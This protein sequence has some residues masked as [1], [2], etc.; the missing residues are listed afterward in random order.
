MS[1]LDNVINGSIYKAKG[2]V[3]EVKNSVSGISRTDNGSPIGLVGRFEKKQPPGFTPNE[4]YNSNGVDLLKLDSSKSS[5]NISSSW[6]G[7]LLDKHPDFSGIGASEKYV[8]LGTSDRFDQSKDFPNYK[9]N[10]PDPYRYVSTRDSYLM[11][12]DLSTDYFKHGLHIIDKKTPLRSDGTDRETWDGHENGTPLRLSQILNGTDKGTPYENN[13]PVIFGF[14]LVFD[15]VSSPL[16]NGSV[17]DFISQFSKISEVAARGNMIYDFK[18]QFSKLFK[19][20]GSIVMGSISPSHK[21]LSIPTSNYATADN[22][23]SNVYQQGKKAYMSY[24]LKSISGLENL[25]ESNTPDKKKYITDYRK[26][27]LKLKFTEDVSLNLG[28]LSHL[29][30]LLYWSKPLGKNIIPEN[31]LRFNC[32]IIVSEVRNLNRVRKAIDTGNLEVVKDNLSRHIYSLKECQLWFDQSPH[33]NEV[34]MSQAAKDFDSFTVTMDYKYVT[35]KFERW[36]PDSKGFGQYA[37]YNN[38]AIWKIGN[39]GRTESKTIASSI[40]SIYTLGTNTL[41]QNGVGS[42][43]VMQT[44]GNVI[45][46]IVQNQN[47]STI[48]KSNESDN[49]SNGTDSRKQPTKTTFE[50][51]KDASK[52][53]STKLAKNLEKAFKIEAQTQINKRFQLLNNTLDKIRNEAGLGRM[54]E[55]TNVYRGTLIGSAIKNSLREFAG[56]SLSSILGD[57]V[58]KLFKGGN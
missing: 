51:F 52:K 29:Y 16:L 5:I 38:G 40:P 13:D 45:D 17:E 48:N 11:F 43:I 50:K 31:L 56:D 24:Y 37:G 10:I 22:S 2:T 35:S 44:Y 58:G 47:D 49:S 39:P 46:P 25:I 32:D 7:V 27:V 1:F 21:T 33:D 42:P 55:P 34:D 54:T 57:S 20:K 6:Y 41:K 15:A 26:D 53:S 19:T 28:T 12:N 36:V 23:Q 8:K 9:D 14:E 30:K 4:Y 18:Q 3:S